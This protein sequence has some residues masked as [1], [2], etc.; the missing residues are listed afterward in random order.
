[1]DDF[2][3]EQL[4]ILAVDDEKIVLDQYSEILSLPSFDLVNCDQGDKAISI[5]RKALE[6]NRPFAVAFID[7]RLASGPDGVQ[8][9]EHIRELDPHTELV[10]V[11]GYSDIPPEQIASRVP[12]TDKLLYLHK[13]FDTYEIR[14]IATALG[15]KWRENNLLRKVHKELE[16][17][18][19]ERSVELEKTNKELDRYIAKQKRA[20]AAL[21]ESREI[22]YS[23]MRHLPAL[24]FMKDRHGRYV[25]LNEAYRSILRVDPATRLG[26]T[27]DEL[28]P[29]GVAKHLRAND[30]IVMSG[31]EV[32]NVIESVKIEDRT[33]H[34]L[35]SKFPIFKD[36]KPFFVGGIAVDIT[37][38]VVAEEKLRNLNEELEQR[39]AERTRQL[40]DANRSLKDAFEN[41][42]KLA[43]EAEAANIAKSEFLTNMTHEIRTPMNSIIG[44]CDLATG[45]T[46][47]P[48]QKEYLSII[49]FSAS[50]LL[51]LINDILDFSKMDANGINFENVP[52]SLREVIE[53]VANAF[54][55][56]IWEKRL[57]LSVDIASDVPESLISD[58]LRLRQ[59]LMNL[60]SNA[61]KFTDKGKVRIEC[62]VRQHRAGEEGREACTELLFCVRDTGIGI[63]PE[64]RN[65]LFAAFTQAD[66]SSARKY[67][68]TGLGLAICK[69][70]VEMMDGDIWMESS[71][72]NGS[73]FY[74]TAC[75]KSDSVQTG[76]EED[77][78]ASPE[79]Q[80]EAIPAPSE[81]GP[82]KYPDSLPGLK[83]REGVKRLAGSWELYMDLL[84]FFC[85]DRKTFCSELMSLIEKENFENAQISAHS[86]KG[87][88]ATIS[89]SELSRFAALLEN[90]CHRK[91]TE[92]ISS[93]L[94]HVEDCIT[95][96]RSSYEELSFLIGD[97][98]KT[99]DIQNDVPN[100]DENVSQACLHELFQK[101]D[102]SLQEFDPL[103]SEDCL[104][105]IRLCLIPDRLESDTGNLI[106]NLIQETRNYDFDDARETLRRL[107][108]KSEAGN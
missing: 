66:G 89:A 65:R 31:E 45:E 42:Q 58:A 26:R 57:E 78:Q 59:V 4:R 40:E 13:P 38:R 37:D 94:K 60:V 96:V 23:F 103:A 107:M 68:G 2:Q 43:R 106:R 71:P 69:R 52:F 27:D 98:I 33:L 64:L 30:K 41:S 14:Q 88:A 5:V 9:A 50:T 87:A 36:G 83:L 29:P 81:A 73:A 12:P 92:D 62:S 82:R 102:K 100:S 54:L 93:L 80:E 16:C 75:F 105:E 8:T 35:V 6:E 44:M 95:E 85:N 15:T 108:Q 48:G 17:R 10:I 32:L 90:A 74:F 28:W 67:G 20:E 84:R 47:D 22:F 53:D 39:V 79:F 25:Y 72:G 3:H 18:V 56:K 21:R 104:R 101:L 46:S 86:L 1:M 19:E 63:A 97:D 7:I 91:D 11:T 61:V 51:E 24:T 76:Y 77:M 34:H 99:D 70:I 49:R 55:E